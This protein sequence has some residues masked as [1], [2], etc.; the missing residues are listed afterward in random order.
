MK[1]I[2][3]RIFDI[4][5]FPVTFLFAHYFRIMRKRNFTSM[6]LSKKTMFSV[7]V[8]PILDHYYEPMF[9]P[10]YLKYSLRENRNLPGIDFNTQEQLDLL[11]KFNYNEELLNFPIEKEN[12]KIEFCYND[13]MF[14]SGDAEYLYNLI[15]H[16]KPGKIIE[17]GSGHSTLMAINALKQNQSSDE[18]S[19]CE[20]ICIEPYENKWLE[21]TNVKIIRKM[22]ED[23]DMSLFQSLKAGDIMFIDSTH[24]IRPQGDVLFE[25]LELLPQLN[26]G[27][28]IHIHDIFTPKDYLDEWV[29]Q[30]RFWNEQYLLEAFLSNNKDFRIIGATNYLMH[31]HYNDFVKKCPVLK[32]Q[33]ENGVDREPGSFWIMKN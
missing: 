7:G 10:K 20:H 26:S 16:F 2:V 31:N 8:F 4:I 15:R 19:T 27:V 28:I 23:I 3:Y 29:N 30:P 11:Q 21:K 1:S 9:N 18:T 33:R 22:V 6:P 13:G 5:L 32:M 17:V 14:R 12:N 25:Y 24:M